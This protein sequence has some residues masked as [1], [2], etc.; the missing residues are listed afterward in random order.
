[1]DDE[2]EIIAFNRNEKANIDVE[3][4]QN[5]NDTRFLYLSKRNI[6]KIREDLFNNLTN[7]KYLHLGENKIESLNGN[8]FSS[9]V[10]LDTLFLSKNLIKDLNENLFKNLTKLKVLNLSNNKIESLNGNVFS[11]LEFLVKLNVSSNLIKDL[12]ENLFT[13]LT[14]LKQLYLDVNKIKFLN[15][16]LFNSL[17]SLN[18]LS[19]ESCE[20]EDLDVDLLSCN[21]RLEYI[22]FSCNKV[23]SIP[24]DFFKNLNEL[25]FIEFLNNFLTK[26]NF[27]WFSNNKKLESINFFNNQLESTTDNKNGDFIINFSQLNNLKHINLSSNCI[28]SLKISN[29]NEDH[30]LE[31]LNV[32]HNLI[33]YCDEKLL[34]FSNLKELLMKGNS[35]KNNFK[36]ENLIRNTNNNLEIIG[37]EGNQFSS[38]KVQMLKHECEKRKLKFS[39]ELNHLHDKGYIKG[40]C[41]GNNQAKFKQL[42]NF[43]WSVIP[44]FSVL[45]G[46]N[47]TGKTSILHF[48]NESLKKSSEK[49]KNDELIT[50]FD[51]NSRIYPLL[52]LTDKQ[53]V[54]FDKKLEKESKE[55]IEHVN[56][57]NDQSTPMKNIKRYHC[58]TYNTSNEQLSPLQQITS[59]FSFGSIYSALK[60]LKYDQIKLN[61]FLKQESFKYQIYPNVEESGKENFVFKETESSN[62]I[63]NVEQLSSG[64]KY[65]LLFLLWKYIYSKYDHIGNTI[66]L[67]DEPDAHMHPSAVNDFLKI[68]KNLVCLGIQVIMTTHNPT[69]VSLI[70]EENLFYIFRDKKDENKLKI[71]RENKNEIYKHLTSNMIS[72]ES[73][74]RTLFVEGNDSKFYRLIYNQLKS[75]KRSLFF[76]HLN[77]L[78]A[79]NENVR[80]KS[81]L[82]TLANFMKPSYNVQDNNS[83][84]YESIYALVDDDGDILCN[85]RVNLKN[86][87][88]LDRYS[89]ENYVLDPV[90]IALFANSNKNH[91]IYKVLKIDVDIN[92]FKTMDIVSKKNSIVEILEKFKGIIKKI[93]FD[94]DK[95]EKKTFKFHKTSFELDYPFILTVQNKKKKC[96]LYRNLYSIIGFN[97]EATKSNENNNPII[98]YFICKKY[99]K[100]IT[101][102]IKKDFDE[103]EPEIKIQLK[104]LSTQMQ[105]SIEDCVTI[106]VQKKNEDVKNKFNFDLKFCNEKQSITTSKRNYI[107]KKMGNSFEYYFKLKELAKQI[108]I[109][110]NIEIFFSKFPE[111]TE[112]KDI[113][114][115]V[116]SPEST[117]NE[118]PA[119]LTKDIRSILQ[120]YLDSFVD[121]LENTLLNETVAIKLDNE[122]TIEYP[123]IFIQLRG[124]DLDEIIYKKVFGQSIAKKIIDYFLSSKANEI[125][126]P[127][128]LQK[129]FENLSKLLIELDENN[130]EQIIFNSNICW[131]V[132]FIG[133]SDIEF[134]NDENFTKA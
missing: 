72:V 51:L 102:K 95:K 107:K 11:S 6:V 82:Q 119:N 32:N 68:L 26:F 103:Q 4:I 131:F 87:I 30:I 97:D 88:Y 75:K 54:E 96:L 8:V 92:N 21:R 23:K 28:R 116:G 71:K 120:G 62:I 14:N 89:L 7:L 83:K 121:L 40:L 118:N 15:S 46:N 101:E 76:Y 2:E 33:S 115:M 113:E 50:D 78:A 34:G 66:L 77:I 130:F 45:T 129:K 49:T 91:N 85:N 29:L 104:N 1:M 59:I 64:E 86:L 42:N 105:Q 57:V 70:D 38:D 58:L 13:N 117:I 69:T 47:G 60:F 108:E 110:R 22:S 43:N 134:L 52:I 56:Y 20:I 65:I 125:F 44:M 12:N 80:N 112:L 63:V 3:T 17:A 39:F 24:V 41:I 100:E 123:K 35:L 25:K 37:L 48:I 126:I 127:F 109:K 9:L 111:I 84:K 5:V 74:S 73:P 93:C 31:Y 114:L 18:V 132:K 128:E 61:K 98:F 90:N 106:W 133:K 94:K 124:H 16:R 67:F 122:N 99:L 10:S 27:D 36:I 79:P 55:F 19:L 53:V 81:N